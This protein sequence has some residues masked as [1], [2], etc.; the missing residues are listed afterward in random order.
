MGL[1]VIDKV[2]ARCKRAFSGSARDRVKSLNCL[3]S[4][5]PAPSIYS[6]APIRPPLLASSRQGTSSDHDSTLFSGFWYPCWILVLFLS[7]FPAVIFIFFLGFKCDCRR[8]TRGDASL[9]SGGSS[10]AP[11]PPKSW[12]TGQNVIS[13]RVVQFLELSTTK[14]ADPTA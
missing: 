2:G 12:S 5:R 3:V 7:C 6:E 11:H 13:S 1:G 8:T 4:S 10:S 9:V 14:T